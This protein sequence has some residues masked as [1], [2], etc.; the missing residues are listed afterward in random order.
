MTSVRVLDKCDL[1][2]ACF[3]MELSRAAEDS[4]FDIIRVD[5][6]RLGRLRHPGVTRTKMSGGGPPIKQ[7]M[8]L[9]PNLYGNGMPV[10]FVN[11]MFILIR[12]GVE[13]EVDK[14]LSFDLRFII[15]VLGL[16]FVVLLCFV[17]EDDHFYLMGTWWNGMVKAKWKIYLS[18]V[19]MVFVADKP[20]NNFIAFDM[21]L[22]QLQLK[23][24]YC[25]NLTFIFG[26]A[27]WTWIKIQPADFLCNNISGLVEPVVPNDLH[28]A[29]CP[30]HS[31]K[32][33]FK[34]GG[35]FSV[36]LDPQIKFGLI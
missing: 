35:W 22:S 19:C 8:A 20:T 15:L 16:I 17:D 12:D 23:L 14:I 34:E 13:F 5:A 7:L 36:A 32:I 11:E 26:A 9:D 31:F 28:R 10:V 6:S 18:N 33:L 4:F 24:H 2:E 21:P 1:S 30:T 29:F 25:Y 27:L 3:H